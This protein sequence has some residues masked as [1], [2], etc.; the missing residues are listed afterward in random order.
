VARWKRAWLL[1]TAP[2]QRWHSR[3]GG[4]RARSQKCV[5]LNGLPPA[6]SPLKDAIK[7]VASSGQA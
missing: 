1:I 6:H 2:V 3:L 4:I 7:Y 5:P